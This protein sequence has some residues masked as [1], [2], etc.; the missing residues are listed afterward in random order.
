MSILSKRQEG[1]AKIEEP[2]EKRNRLKNK[3]RGEQGSS[4]NGNMG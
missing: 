4:N 1:M 2:S 3:N